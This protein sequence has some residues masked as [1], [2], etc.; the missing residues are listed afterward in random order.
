MSDRLSR[1]QSSLI[2]GTA[3]FSAII[4]LWMIPVV[5]VFISAVGTFSSPTV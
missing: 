3:F 2:C 1:S 5:G 4:V